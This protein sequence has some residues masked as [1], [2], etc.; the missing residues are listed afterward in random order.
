MSF[1]YLL[2][3]SENSLPGIDKSLSQHNPRTF[4]DDKD[5]ADKRPV[6]VV[7]NKDNYHK[8]SRFSSEEMA[9]PIIIHNQKKT[10]RPVKVATP[11]WI[12]RRQHFNDDSDESYETEKNG[13]F[14]P[15]PNKKEDGKEHHYHYIPYQRQRKTSLVEPS[16]P[17]NCLDWNFVYMN[18]AAAS[19]ATTK[20]FLEKIHEIVAGLGG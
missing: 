14:Q 4:L 8:D 18:D 10:Q 17:E 20:L 9:G 1:F 5:G 3:N 15:R 7:V 16:R 6:V 12:K 19:A 2:H 11:L 13:K